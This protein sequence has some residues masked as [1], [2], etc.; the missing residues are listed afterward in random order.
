ML[1][2]ET[3]KN[4]L[5]HVSTKDY[6]EAQRNSCEQV[7]E[8]LQALQHFCWDDDGDKSWKQ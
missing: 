2:L 6:A 5:L 8:L 4:Q 3:N 1:K 7:C